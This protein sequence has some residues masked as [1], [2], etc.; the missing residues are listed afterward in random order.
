MTTEP[1]L[2]I[3][4][5]YRLDEPV[6]QGGMGR[7]WRGHDLLLDRVVA[8][9]ELL[10]PARAGA[11]ERET[12]LARAARE[13]RA[14][15]RLNHAGVVTIHDV[16]EHDGTPWIVMEFIDGRTLAAE[17]AAAGRLP[18]PRAAQ[19]GA[20]IVG[21]L[22]AAHAA[23][24]VHRD[25]KPENVLLAG[26][27]VVVTDFGIARL[28]D[29]T[30]QLTGT[31]TVL[32]TPDYMA[33]E[34][35]EGEPVGPPADLWA[36]GGTLYAMT[37]GK[38]P[39]AG[40]TL[41]AVVAAILASDPPAPADAGPLTPLI[42]RLLAKDPAARPTAAA[43]ARQLSL[44]RF[45]A[46]N[47][48]AA[49]AAGQAATGQEV[50]GQDATGQDAGAARQD[51]VTIA[52][53]PGGAGWTPP[54]GPPPVPP[55]TVPPPLVPPATVPPA[56]VPPGGPWSAAGPGFVTSPGSP[57]W[58][59]TR[60]GQLAVAVPV[61]A[62]LAALAG[63]LVAAPG[64]SASHPAAGAS[65]ATVGLTA[66]PQGSAVLRATP[67]AKPTPAPKPPPVGDA[68]L[69]G[70]WR[71]HGYHTTTTFD[72]A[73]VA[74]AGGS[75]NV[76]HITAAGVDTDVY[77]PDALPFYGTYN[78]STLEEELLGEDLTSLRANPRNHQV[79]K[80]AQ[81]W[82]VSSSAKYV[83]QGSTS[84]GTFDKPDS[85]PVTYT[86]RCTASTLTWTYK[87]KQTDVESRVSN[88]P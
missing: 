59:R 49:N 53:P 29:A 26:S 31:G 27:R 73:T 42:A 80:V 14:A 34:Q 65:P 2:V 58:W 74:L 48:T 12:L 46:E 8:V 20:K 50:A 60:R 52:R 87:G 21:A 64:G 1:G 83:Y 77:G 38:P 41:T 39:F 54:A 72:G 35:L 28:D 4:A 13:A 68:C 70:S 17:V 85:T 82:T 40:P 66:S 33:P 84:T 55:A 57:A 23:G 15:A 18:W 7:V 5:R 19:I 43:T 16:V 56:M 32:G 86:Y 37:E 62:A 10:L 25:L 22:A 88:Q 3:G 36:L 47:A 63:F 11:R 61:V 9:K 76:D 75:G 67:T 79:I 81:G 45:A 44:A 71:D 69:V 6:G 24:I 51:T 78:G 30:G